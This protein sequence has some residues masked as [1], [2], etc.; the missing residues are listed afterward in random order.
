MLEFPEASAITAQLNETISGKRIINVVAAQHSHKLAWYYGDPQNYHELLCNKVIKRTESHGGLVEIMAGD[1][2]ILLGD[3]I[4][5]RYF[6]DGEKLPA[7]HQLFIEFEDFS[8]IVASVQMYGSLLAYPFGKND[9]PYYL[10]AKEKTNPLSENFDEVYFNDIIS[11][12]EKGLSLKAFLAT[13]QRIPGFGNGVL[14]DVLFNA[15]MHPKKKLDT[16]ND[17]DI[18]TLFNSIKT[19]LAEMTFGGGR[20]TERD[21]FG[22]YGGY[23]TILCKSTINKPCSICGDTLK[24]ESYMGGNIYFCPTCQKL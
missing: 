11:G 5:L 9:N 15:K 18:H 19:T 21:L 3:G 7:K 22:C 16:L 20:D 2:C 12:S 23:K 6:V 1:A 13:K 17:L 4:N 14:Q 10:I 8:S 24:K